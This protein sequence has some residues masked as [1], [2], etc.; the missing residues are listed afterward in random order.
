MPTRQ[1]RDEPP[2]TLP[3]PD[4]RVPDP[5]A[6]DAPIS[7]TVSREPVLLGEVLFHTLAEL[8]RRTPD[9]VPALPA[10]RT[11]PHP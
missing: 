11:R 5:R 4:P 6:M 1:C 10:Q 7:P 8:A 2:P 9:P 3:S